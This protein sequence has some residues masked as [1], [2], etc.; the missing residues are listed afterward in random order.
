VVSRFL[1][2]LITA[3]VAVGPLTTDLYLPSLPAIASAFAVDSAKVQLSLS[4]FLLTFGAAQLI[5]GPLSDYFGRRPVLVV[6]LAIYIVASVL[7]ARVQSVEALI[8]F[9]ALQAFAAC[10]A[11]VVGRAMVRDLFEGSA[12]IRAM[13]MIGAA[14]ALAPVLGPLA[15]GFL[16]EWFGFR[17]GFYVLAVFGLGL[18]VA[19][20]SMLGETNRHRGRG[21]GAP[22][23]VLNSYKV[24]IANPGYRGYVVGVACAFAGLFLFLSESSFV[25][26]DYMGLSPSDYGIGF[27]LVACGYMAGNAT[28]ARLSRRFPPLTMVRVGA[29]LCFA[30]GAA[31]VFFALIGIDHPAAIIGPMFGY[32]AGFGLIMPNGIAG[33]IAPFPERAGAASALLG[34]SQMGF[35]A[36]VGWLVSQVPHTDQMPMVIGVTT[37]GAMSFVAFFVLP[38]K[39]VR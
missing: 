22:F 35:S 12:A 34:F 11:T 33:A 23:D 28:S 18:Y 20:W 15:G 39:R 7:C 8:G 9:R 5:H 37:V 4:V 27:G 2:I 21:R 14:M 29:L 25:M 19:V 13:A 38:K 3:L 36:F 31:G 1:I 10:S 32:M 6:G 26:I 16:E 24:L 17:A 30:S